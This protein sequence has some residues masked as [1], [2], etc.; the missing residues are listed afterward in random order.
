MII[1][2]TNVEEPGTVKLSTVQPQ[3]GTE[4]TAELTDP[5]GDPTRVVWQWARAISPTGSYTNVSSGV[6]H[7]S[8]TPV[9]ADVGQYLRAFATYEDLQGGSK[10][11][12]GV[13][14]NP[15]Q[16]APA[17]NNS[18]PVF[19]ERTAARSVSENTATGDQ[20]RHTGHRQRRQQRYTDLHA[21]RSRRGLLWNRRS[22]RAV[23]DRGPIGL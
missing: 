7:A 20:L 8:Y 18:A 17:G 19:S 4:V 22:V 13:S 15:V 1:E 16:A 14:D 23:A 3:V 9:A 2:V 6:D 21:W 12:N 5:D 11:A 10:T